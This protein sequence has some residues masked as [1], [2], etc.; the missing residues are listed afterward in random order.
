MF[1]SLGKNDS[2][3]FNITSAIGK[4][5][6]NNWCSS[7]TS[8]VYLYGH[9]IPGIALFVF[10]LTFNPIA[11]YYFATS[12]NFRRSAYSYYFSAIAVV[13]LVRLTVWCL[14]FLLDF[15][16]FKLNFRPFECPFQLF[17]ESVA[18][19][20]S[21]WLAVSLTV[22]RCLVIYK[23]LQTLTDTRGKRALRLIFCVVVLSCLVNS[24]VLQPGFYVKRAYRENSHSIVCHYEQSPTANVTLIKQSSFLTPNAKRIYLLIIV[25]FRV[26]VPFVLLFTANI[27][28]FISVR[29]SRQDSSKLSSSLLIRHGH[30][31]SVT[32]MIFFSS[33]ILL[34]TISPRYLLQ[35]YLNFY[36][37]LPDCSLTHFAPH[38][39]K[40]LELFNYASNVFVSIVSGK[41]GRYELFNMLMCRTV[42]TQTLRFTTPSRLVGLSA[43]NSL[44]ASKSSYQRRTNPKRNERNKQSEK[45]LLPNL[46]HLNSNSYHDQY[47]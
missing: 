26:A 9:L 8:S 47:Q 5:T 45:L 27:V 18:S 19:S 17:I 32:P 28:L 23:P 38:I 34:L 1:D 12:R 24:L 43:P 2:S 25:I 42:P 30:H 39:L 46:N 10:G 35:F 3:T 29:Q 11:L 44:L 36:Q 13:D 4:T 33:C 40:T 37:R 41:H 22:E 20:I 31:R 15:K 14:F 7:L 6:Y 16:I 21:A